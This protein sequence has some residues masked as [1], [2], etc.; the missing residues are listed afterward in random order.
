MGTKKVLAPRVARAIGPLPDGPCLDLFAGMCSVAGELSRS[1]RSVWCNDVQGYAE[2]VARA[3]VQSTE[4]PPTGFDAAKELSDA[5]SENGGILR[6]RFLKDLRAERAALAG[7]YNDY[8]AL[9]QAWAHV[10]NDAALAEEAARERAAETRE[11]PYRLATIAFAHGYFGLGQSIEIDSIRYALDVTLDA[12]AISAE[13]HRWYLVALLQ[14]ASHVVSAPGHFAQF[15]GVRDADTFRR[16]RQ[17]RA[18]LVWPQ[19]VLELGRLRPYGTSAW[20]RG[21][22]VFSKPADALLQDLRGAS[23]RPSVIYADP[24]YTVDQ[25]S[26]YYHVL[27]TLTRYDYPASA[28][29]GRYRPDRFTSP[30]SLASKVVHAF[31]GLASDVAEI[32]AVLVLSYP[33]TG[34]LH[35][36]LKEEKHEELSDLLR[37][38]FGRIDVTPIPYRHSTM[39]GSPG[40]SHAGVEELVYVADPDPK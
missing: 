6:T 2:L 18:R 36:K 29:L 33:S 4:T 8:T 37:R 26:R 11:S 24:P 28:S 25:Y 15:F 13:R 3:L 32:G 21:N 27:E 10:G 22:R 1:R 20:R 38:H 17:V 19:F 12:G 31:E 16:V 34:L 30:F 39:G 23:E 35:R 14:A 9:V 40:W 7:S 5:V